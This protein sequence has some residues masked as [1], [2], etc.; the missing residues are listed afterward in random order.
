MSTIILRSPDRVLSTD[1]H[2]DF[3]VRLPSHAQPS[4]PFTLRL[5]SACILLSGADAP[6]SVHCSLG[7]SA[8]S[9]VVDTRTGGSSCCIGVLMSTLDGAPGTPVIKYPG[10]GSWNQI[11]VTLRNVQTYAVR[12]DVTHC[13]LVLS[14]D[15]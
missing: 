4:G 1:S 11:R 13:T 7:S 3:T 6:I 14:L 12:T 9:G 15:E 10:V 8:P 2:S 5:V